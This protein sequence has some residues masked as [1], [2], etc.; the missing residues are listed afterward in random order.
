[1]PVLIAVAFITLAERK[2]LG[3]IQRRRG[4]N[5]VGS[6]GFLQAFADGLKLFSEEIFLPSQI[7]LGLYFFVAV[8]ALGVAF[9]PWGVIPYGNLFMD[10]HLGILYLFFVSSI[11]VY[12]VLMSG[13][14]SN[15]KY[16]FDGAV[17]GTAQMVSYEVSIGLLFLS[18]CLCCRPLSLSE[19]VKVQEGVWLAFPLFPIMVMFFV[20]ALAETNRVPFDLTEGESELVSGF[21]VEY[22]SFLFDPV[23]GGDPI[24]F[25]HLFWFFGHP[26]VYVLILPG[27]GI[28]SQVIVVFSKKQ[29]FG[30]LGM[31]YAMVSIGIL[32]FIVWAHHMFTVGMDVDTRAYFTAATMIIAIP[33]GIKIFSWIMTAMGGELVFDTPMLWVAGFVFLFTMG[34]LTGIVLANSS[35]DVVLHDTYYVVAHFHY[36]LSMGAVFSIFAG[37]YFWFGKIT[38]Y[39]YNELLGRVHFWLMFIGVNLTFFPQHFLG[40]AGMPRRYSDFP[41]CFAGWNMVSSF[42]SVIS[43]VSIMVFFYMVYD[44]LKKQILFRGLCRN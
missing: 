1:M 26:E 43:L 3:I 6:G 41:D 18:V 12:A 31:V 22:R 36:V 8:F 10:L 16:A 33:T 32:G 40:L 15:S 39:Q 17:R 27:F 29:I 37:T 20:S 4:P 30:Y 19:I 5:I 38:G 11:S 25:Q 21:N 28:V 13:W 14:V 23:G 9:L 44:A 35:L 42:G 24:L 34:G 2:L 7:N